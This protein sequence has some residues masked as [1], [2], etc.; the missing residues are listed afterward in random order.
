MTRDG[1]A[2][3]PAVQAVLTRD[4][5]A[6]RAAQLGLALSA[7]DLDELHRGWTGLQP[8]LARVRDGLDRW[9]RPA[10]RFVLPGREGAGAG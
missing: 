1:A 8:Q 3:R 2:A 4:E 5:F 6:A 9:E 7:E 10:H